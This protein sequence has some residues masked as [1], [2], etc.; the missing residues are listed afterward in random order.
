MEKNYLKGTLAKKRNFAIF[1]FSIM[2]PGR[3]R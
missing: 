2:K 3:N 1:K